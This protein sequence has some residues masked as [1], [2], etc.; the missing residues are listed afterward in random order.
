MSEASLP[1]DAERLQRNSEAR[2]REVKL[3]MQ[4]KWDTPEFVR[5]QDRQWYARRSFQNRLAGSE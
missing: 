5:E 2:A 4:E 3:K 1:Q